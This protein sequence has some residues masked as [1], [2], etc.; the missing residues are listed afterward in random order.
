MVKSGHT[1]SNISYTNVGKLLLIKTV[2]SRPIK[3]H[4]ITN[5]GNNLGSGRFVKIAQ[6]REKGGLLL[7]QN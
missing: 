1:T 2:P 4:S 5:F 7:S 3:F 6:L